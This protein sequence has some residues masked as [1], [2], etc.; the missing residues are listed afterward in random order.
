L[1]SKGKGPLVNEIE[2][3]IARIAD[4]RA[5]LA[6]SSRFRGYAPEAVALLGLLTLI[7]TV[8]QMVWPDLFAAN[9]EQVVRAWG[10]LLAG[11]FVGIAL[12][13]VIRTLRQNDGMASPAL[14]SAMRIAVPGT[15]MA[16]AIPAAVLAYAPQA[17]WI[18]PGT[19]Q[20]LIG[21]VA[22]GS[23]PL[24][25]RRIVWPGAWFI[26]SGA[27]GLL[28]AGRQGG[29]SPILV[30]APFVVGHFGIAWALFERK[31]NSRAQ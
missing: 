12:E 8:M 2:Q 6:A 23:Y 24:M 16:A 9:D 19:W 28:L 27:A 22:F 18:V 21:L 10:I 3:A 31:H 25:P 13:A 26:L 17:C 29:L 5:Q 11:G 7:V 20:M 30:G 14:V 4:I 15:I 1:H